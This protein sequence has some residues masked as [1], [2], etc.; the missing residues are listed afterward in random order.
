VPNSY[1]VKLWSCPFA[2]WT[3]EATKEPE[4][5]P[6]NGKSQG[7]FDLSRPIRVFALFF[8]GK[9]FFGFSYCNLPADHY[10]R[11]IEANNAQTERAK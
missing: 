10:N 9:S 1:W 11:G 5:K 4:F 2:A 6:E 7:G 3:G 8:A